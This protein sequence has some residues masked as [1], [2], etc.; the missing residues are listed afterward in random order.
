MNVKYF[1]GLAIASVTVALMTGCSDNGVQ[2][3]SGTDGNHKTIAALQ[4]LAVRDFSIAGNQCYAL[5]NVIAP[6]PPGGNYYLAQ[7]NNSSNSWNQLPHYGKDLAVSASKKCYHVNA[8]GEIWWAEE[9]VDYG[10]RSVLCPMING[11]RVKA[12]WIAAG[13]SPNGGKDYLW[14]VGENNEIY[15]CEYTFFVNNPVWTV[16][17]RV[18]DEIRSIAADPESGRRVALTSGISVY[19]MTLGNSSWSQKDF[20]LGM[21]THDVALG[22]NKCVVTVYDIEEQEYMV[23]VNK[24]CCSNE[25]YQATSVDWW[26]LV[27]GVSIKK[28]GFSDWRYYYADCDG[29]IRSGLIN[30]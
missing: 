9:Y 4:D 7:Y 2:P 1:L 6:G 28:S 8:N 29:H 25:F 5:T 27:Y 23:Y 20:G 16:Q 24:K 30:Q 26:C 3:I 14:I 21:F 22:A 13:V 12:R 17:P 15:S 19:R 11:T 18:E 10:D